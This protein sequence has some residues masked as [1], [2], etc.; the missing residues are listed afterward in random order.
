MWLHGQR[1]FR[2]A[3]L[4]PVLGTWRVCALHA[5]QEFYD[6]A[7]VQDRRLG[8]DSRQSRLPGLEFPRRAI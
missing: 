3:L 8:G 5:S 7:P 4:M 2:R 1:A 6:D